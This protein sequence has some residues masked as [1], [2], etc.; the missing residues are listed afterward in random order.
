MTIARTV[1][2][3][4]LAVVVTGCEGLDKDLRTNRPQVADVPVASRLESTIGASRA[5]AVPTAIGSLLEGYHQT[6]V[7]KS[8]VSADRRFAEQAAKTSLQNAPDNETS[9]WT[10][11]SS[12][13]SGTFTPLNSY[14]SDDRYRCRDYTQSVTAD[15]DTRETRGTACQTGP[16]TWKIVEVPITRVRAGGRR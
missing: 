14:Q 16:E 13:H 11:P 1:G 8:L 10:N 12:G 2:V 15:G 3:L 4:T 6:S 5:N 7:G 9:T